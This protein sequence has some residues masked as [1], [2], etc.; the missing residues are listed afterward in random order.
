MNSF[1]FLYRIAYSI[2]KFIKN[3]LTHLKI[4]K[5]YPGLRMGISINWIVRDWRYLKVGT[6]VWIGA[7]SEIAV[8]GLDQPSSIPG[9]LEIGNRVVIGSFANIRAGGGRILIKDNALIGQKVS[10]IAANHLINQDNY[11]RDLPWD[12]NNTG[13]TLEE[14]VWIGTGVIILP[15]CNIGRNSV[16]TAGSLVNRSIPRNQLWGGVPIIHIKDLA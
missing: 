15:G 2:L 4:Y 11:Y 7:F 3:I 12:E 10:L 5:N 16:V 6:G 9:N 8:D 14:N 13:I 1:T